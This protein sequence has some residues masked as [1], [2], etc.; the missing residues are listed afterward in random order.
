MTVDMEHVRA[1]CYAAWPAAGE[2]QAQRQN[3]RRQ[4]FNCGKDQAVERYL[5]GRGVAIGVSIL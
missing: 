1:A 2:T 4:D 3:T 5:A